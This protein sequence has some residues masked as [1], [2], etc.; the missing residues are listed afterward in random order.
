M[1]V[2]IRAKQKP[3]YQRE[4]YENGGIGRIYWNYRDQLALSYLGDQDARVI[5]VGCGEGLTLEKANRLFP[6]KSFIGVDG[7]KDNLLICNEHHLEVMGGDVYQLPLKNDAIDYILFLEVIEHLADPERA[8]AEMHRILRPQGK[9]VMVFPHDAVFKA[10]RVLTLK[11]KEAFY[12][13]G[14]IRQWTP[15]SAKTL[16]NRHGFKVVEQSNIPFSIWTFSLHHLMVCE[17]NEIS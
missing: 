1:P 16:V 2:D 13:P 12:D 10:A 3:L 5:D 4:Q 6:E 15:G 7:L 9:L 17:K 11:L 14:H 8:V